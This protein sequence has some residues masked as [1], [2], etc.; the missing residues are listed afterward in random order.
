MKCSA[1]KA[2]NKCGDG[3]TDIPDSFGKA[4]GEDP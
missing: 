3:T 1:L 4:L 2:G